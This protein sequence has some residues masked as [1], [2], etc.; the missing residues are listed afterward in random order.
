MGLFSV[1]TASGR[2]GQTRGSGSPLLSMRIRVQ[3]QTNVGERQLRN[4]QADLLFRLAAHMHSAV[5]L[6]DDW[7]DNGRT[8]F[9]L[10]EA[11]VVDRMPNRI[12]GKTGSESWLEVQRQADLRDIM[13]Q[14][15]KPCD[16]CI[17][18]LERSAFH[19]L[20]ELGG[21][22][23]PNLDAI[24]TGTTTPAH[25]DLKLAIRAPSDFQEAS[26]LLAG[27]ADHI[28]AAYSH[29]AYSYEVQMSGP[30]S[31]RNPEPP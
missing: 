16:Y 2:M 10:L 8:D 6:L 5:L 27:L 24:A 18:L 20:I 9:K 28:G 14:P 17:A 30:R 1:G 4:A 19:S 15:S 11:F 21:K 31:G 26:A 13:L 23:E 22:F 12:V 7:I 25:Q 3:P 29:I